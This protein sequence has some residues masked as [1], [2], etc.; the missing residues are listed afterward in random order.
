MK[1][2]AKESNVQA[3]TRTMRAAFFTGFSRHPRP[4]SQAA[5]VALF[6]SGELM[7]L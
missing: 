7:Q 1:L 3:E 5:A 2:P 4:P 6:D